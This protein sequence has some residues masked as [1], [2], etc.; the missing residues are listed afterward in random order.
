MSFE[1]FILQIVLYLQPL[2]R[3]EVWQWCCKTKNCC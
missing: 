2:F 1:F 3:S